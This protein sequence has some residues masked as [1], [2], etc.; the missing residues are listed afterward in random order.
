MAREA[1]GWHPE[2]A[3]LSVAV[4]RTEELASRLGRF[5]ARLLD[6]ALEEGAL[7]E[8]DPFYTVFRLP[9]PPMLPEHVLAH[10][11]LE[12]VRCVRCLMPGALVAGRAG[13]LGNQLMQ[14]GGGMACRRC[15]AY[16]F[17]MVRLIGTG[18]H[19]RP[20]DAAAAWRL[21]RYMRGCHPATGAFLGSPLLV[22]AAA[23]SFAIILGED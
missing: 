20:R 9:R 19:G 22:D 3:G 11:R 13:V 17:Q 1:A 15:G 6:Q 14:L 12:Q 18:C 5:Y 23:D 21:R 16:A 10:D 4:N 2:V 8:P 7:P